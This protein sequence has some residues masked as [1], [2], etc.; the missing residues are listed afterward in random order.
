MKSWTKLT[1]LVQ[2]PVALRGLDR[3]IDYARR[4]LDRYEPLPVRKAEQKTLAR[5]A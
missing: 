2:E 5:I 1:A 4:V 3:L